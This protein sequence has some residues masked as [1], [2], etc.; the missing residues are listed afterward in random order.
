MKSYRIVI[1]FS[2]PHSA[3]WSHSNPEK[4]DWH[5]LFGIGLDEVLTVEDVQ[6]IQTSELHREILQEQLGLVEAD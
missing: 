5:E 6:P 2:S 1:E 4:W 3:R